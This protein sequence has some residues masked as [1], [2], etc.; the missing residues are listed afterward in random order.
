LIFDPRPKERLR[1]LFDREVE[2]NKFVNS[3]E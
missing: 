1:D 3:P 2:I